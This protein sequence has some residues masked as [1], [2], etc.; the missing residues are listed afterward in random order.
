MQSHQRSLTGRVMRSSYWMLANSGI[1]KLLTLVTQIVLSTI[2]AKDEFGVYA[3]AISISALLTN[4]RG[5]GM[6]QWLVQGGKT[7]FDNRAGPAF[8]TGIAFNSILAIGI[9][10]V[11]FPAGE[12]FNDS[13][14]VGVVIVSG[15]S[16]P[17]LSFGSYYKTEMS[18]D[19]RMREVTLIEVASAIVRS[20]LM[21]ALALLGF[22]PLSFV[23]PLPISYLVEG[24]GG[25]YCTRDRAWRRSGQLRSWHRLIWRNRWILAGTFIITVGLQADYTILGKMTTLTILG[26]YYFAYQMTY[27][28]ASLVTNNVRRV[29]VPSLV[30]LPSSRRPQAALNAAAASMVIGAPLLM[31]FACVIDPLESLLWSGK[32]A[33]AVLPIQVLS[34]GLPLE[35][36]TAVTQATLQSEGKFR[37]WTTVNL[38]RSLFVVIGALAAGVWANDDIATIAIIMTSAFAAANILQIWLVFW[39]LGISAWTLVRTTI[40]GTTIAPAAL[41]V[42]L[43]G[44]ASIHLPNIW[45]LV[46]AS[47]AYFALYLLLVAIVDLRALKAAGTSLTSS[48][49]R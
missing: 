2:L 32:W 47:V 14:V 29:L 11:A 9:V 28:S 35:L 36:L 41:L 34:L 30:S 15:L 49:R 16:F 44:T 23:L 5:G 10:A 17:L 20:V 25:Y 19:L 24:L 7:D 22:G 3:I 31:V 1:V 48:L 43:M 26:V 4:F 12:F 8:W 6:L 18:M 40:S 27:M 46:V 45:E 38:I 39:N 13:R 33:D 42:V 37:L 21:V